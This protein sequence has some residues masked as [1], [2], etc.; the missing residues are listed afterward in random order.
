MAHAAPQFFNS[1]FNS[2]AT[3]V[4]KPDGFLADT[5][6]VQ[7]AKSAH[8]AELARANAAA[9]RSFDQFSDSPSFAPASFASSPSFAVPRNSFQSLS[10]PAAGIV[11]SPEG[12]LA[13]TA[14]VAKAKAVHYAALASAVGAPTDP[15]TRYLATLP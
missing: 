13:D 3:P 6:E 15:Y 4:V 2:F 7:A 5:P 11:V 9:P 1:G 8:L 12:F 10:N 14:D